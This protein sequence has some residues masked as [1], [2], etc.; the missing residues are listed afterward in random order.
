MGARGRARPSPLR[1][2]PS[3]AGA[4][5]RDPATAIGTYGPIAC[6]YGPLKRGGAR[7]WVIRGRWP[8]QGPWAVTRPGLH[9]VAQDN[10]KTTTRQLQDNSQDNPQDNSKH[11][12]KSRVRPEQSNKYK[13]EKFPYFHECTRLPTK[14]SC[15]VGCLVSCLV[16]VL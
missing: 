6:K 11:L 10:Y 3:R 8:C 1:S 14:R 13:Y 2:S 16:V 15:L 7:G 5:T 4:Q 9:R 12:T